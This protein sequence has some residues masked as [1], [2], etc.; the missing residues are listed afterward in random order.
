M[1]WIELL[2]SATALLL[3][4]A[5]FWRT[6]SADPRKDTK[7]L[8]ILQA[9]QDL[10]TT[11]DSLPGRIADEVSASPL[12]EAVEGVRESVRLMGESMGD[13][14]VQQTKAQTA[15]H[16]GMELGLARNLESQQA[17]AGSVESGVKAVVTAVQ[18]ASAAMD[19]ALAKVSGEIVKIPAAIAQSATE[20][21]RSVATGAQQTADHVAK[22][23]TESAPK[24]DG[25]SQE[26]VLAKLDSAVEGVQQMVEVQRHARQDAQ[27]MAQARER[28]A[29]SQLQALET[30]RT[31]LGALSLLESL[32]TSMD[33]AVRTLDARLQAMLEQAATAQVDA[34][35]QAT[36]Q[37]EQ[38]STERKEI[39]DA[40]ALVVAGL[41]TISRE[42][43]VRIAQESAQRPAPHPELEELAMAVRDSGHLRGDVGRQVAEA[44][45]RVGQ[46]LSESG[47]R[48]E[49]S[50]ERAGVALDQA[51]SSLQELAADLRVSL[52]PLSEAL[53]GHGQLVAPLATA[54]GA[55]RDR[56]EEASTS[57][58]ANQV[59]FSA[60]VELF[61]QGA[62]ELQSGLALFAR[63]GEKEGAE[64]P[65]AAQKALLEALER[66]LG[67]FA[68]S[69]KAH[70]SESDLRMR[71]TL[72]ELATRLPSPQG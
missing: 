16:A 22:A 7:D 13:H 47:S 38:A 41:D 54:L 58:R 44:V 65:R 52:S 36:L 39:A 11:L 63:E 31:S 29:A 30:L 43:P 35:A 34:L 72:T 18:N 50:R 12:R 8:A 55:A 46:Q 49:E 2:L 20:V 14:L 1:N 53:T 21:T 6:W 24:S 69:L 51:L 70:L 10:R 9:F 3:A 66:L 60:S 23:L 25:T 57:L 61:S 5:A 37:L 48:A 27:T 64:D 56:L 68:D 19:A 62:Q 32:S 59:E 33:V 4:A 45:G 40:V 15:W 71:E 67:G 26:I 17:V 42:M 28:D